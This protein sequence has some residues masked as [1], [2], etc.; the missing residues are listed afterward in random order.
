MECRTPH[1]FSL[2]IFL[3]TLGWSELKAGKTHQEI[4]RHQGTF[5][6]VF[7][8]ETLLFQSIS[9]IKE[10]TVSAACKIP[11][12][13]VWFLLLTGFYGKSNFMYLSQGRQLQRGAPRVVFLTVQVVKRC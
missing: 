13:S 3:K 9:V 1:Y 4:E 7:D 8:K 6:T 2:V 11:V 12:P 10:K 5:M